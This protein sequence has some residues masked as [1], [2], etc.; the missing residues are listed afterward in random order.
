MQSANEER[1]S[2]SVNTSA[3][4]EAKYFIVQPSDR[5]DSLMAL[6]GRIACYLPC[7]L[8]ASES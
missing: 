8:T 3:I 2:S 7:R 5:N 4:V 6:M 1:A